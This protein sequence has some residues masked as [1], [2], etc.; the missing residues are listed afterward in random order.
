[1]ARI[2]LHAH[3]SAS[4]GTTSPADLVRHAAEVGLDV[5]AL[6]DHDTTAGWDEAAT[7]LPSGLRLVRGAEIS[8]RADGVSLHLLAYLF[9]PYDEPLAEALHA[10]RVSRVGRAERMVERLVADGLPVTWGQVQGLAGGT[11]GRPH[12]AQALV[13]AGLVESV[14]AAFTPSWL[15]VE[16]RYWVG[17]EEL[18]A[19]HAVELVAAAGGVTVFAHPAAAARGRTVGD[20]VV[21]ELAA[22]GLAGLEVEHPDH[23]AQERAHL[24]R[25]A[26]GLDLLVTG[27][28]D[29]HGE[30]KPVTLGAHLTG[31][32][33]YEAI[34]ERA[35]GAAVL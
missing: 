35:T 30:N 24:R 20:H 21:E 2:D 28:S 9:D 34:V 6:T 33:S 19:V 12:V 32:P 7:A 27:A 1:V 3:S 8:C 5:L 18:D 14:A 11:V 25:L 4:D 31:L 15:G 23:T 16:G 10:L 29:Y 17:K 13:D 26:A 22:A